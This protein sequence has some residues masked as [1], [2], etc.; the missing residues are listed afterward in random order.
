MPTR[1]LTFA[2]GLILAATPATASDPD[3]AP[4]WSSVAD[5]EKS[6]AADPQLIHRKHHWGK[7]PLHVAAARG[8]P[9]IVAWLLDHGADVNVRSEVETPPLIE[10]CQ[11]AWAAPRAWRVRRYNKWQHNPSNEPRRYRETVELLLTRGA[12]AK[13][14]ANAK[15]TALHFAAGAGDADLVRL[16]LAAGADAKCAAKEGRTPLHF[17]AAAGATEAARLLLAAGADPNAVEAAEGAMTRDTPLD[18]A[19]SAGSAEVVQLLVDRGADV[20]LPADTDRML[21]RHAVD[22]PAV[23]R[24]LL[25]AG[26]DLAGAANDTTTGAMALQ[27]AA[28]EPE[29]RSVQMLIDAG[30]RDRKSLDVAYQ[31]TVSDDPDPDPI[32][33]LKRFRTVKILLDAGAKLQGFDDRGGP[34][35]AAAHNGHVE[36][37]ILLKSRGARLNYAPST[38]PTTLG[39]NTWIALLNQP[40]RAWL[41]NAIGFK[42]DLYA[43]AAYGFEDRVREILRAHPDKVDG[44]ISSATPLMFACRGGHVKIVKLLIDAGANVNPK[45]ER[46]GWFGAAP[47]EAATARG[48]LEVMR[49]L[50]ARGAD[51]NIAD[52]NGRTLLQRCYDHRDTVRP[53]VVELLRQH[54]AVARAG[55]HDENVADAAT[56]AA[57]KGG[58]SP[59]AR[60]AATIPAR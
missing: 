11:G 44:D 35:F 34:L 25:D 54:G 21:L 17:A 40:W 9:E 2:V 55:R 22:T 29:P 10:A 32:V 18:E 49:V 24:I 1:L 20:R 58:N 42:L 13:A 31:M 12:D 59:A 36:I 47:L 28:D 23:L 51:V 41:L 8:D 33:R 46:G 14:V 27:W 57:S 48:N 26:I 53:Q 6:F 30:V 39:D 4:W 15:V 50:I 52:E 60:N 45:I 7:T 19:A 16:L 43:A 3:W 38:Q 5:L 56:P 37:M